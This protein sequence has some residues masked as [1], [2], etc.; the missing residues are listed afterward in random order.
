MP[1]GTSRFECCGGGRTGALQVSEQP[2][3]ERERE[4]A[5][6]Q[7]LAWSREGEGERAPRIVVV[8]TWTCSR[9]GDDQKD[10]EHV[11]WWAVKKMASRR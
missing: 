7:E 1:A 4:R 6:S 5:W 2:T 3:E 11:R 10:D 9:G 8:S